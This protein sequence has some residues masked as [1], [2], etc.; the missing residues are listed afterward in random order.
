MDWAGISFGSSTFGVVA[1]RTGGVALWNGS[2]FQAQRTPPLPVVSAVWASATTAWVVGEGVLHFNGSAW[3]TLPFPGPWASVHG[4]AA[5]DVWLVGTG[6]RVARWNGSALT[7]FTS[8]ATTDLRAVHALSR[9]AVIVAG[10]GGTLLRFQGVGWATVTSGTSTNLLAL[11]RRGADV[12]A[13]GAQTALRV[14]T[15]GTVTALP[16]F[17]MTQPRAAIETSAGLWVFGSGNATATLHDGTSWLTLTPQVPLS[18]PTAVTLEG[19]RLWL[20]TTSGSLVVIDGAT[21]QVG[22][23]PATRPLVEGLELGADGTVWART[24]E[25]LMH[26]DAGWVVDAARTAAFR[27]L[28][29]R[30]FCSHHST[31]AKAVGTDGGLASQDAGS[32]TPPNITTP[33]NRVVCGARGELLAGVEST[34]GVAY[35][36]WFIKTPTGWSSPQTALGYDY[37]L[38]FF[39]GSDG[40]IIAGGETCSTDSVGRR[41]CVLATG[42]GPEPK[43]TMGSNFFQNAS[44]RYFVAEGASTRFILR[45]TPS[46]N[47]LQRDLKLG[48]VSGGLTTSAHDFT[49]A[50]SIQGMG[51]VDQ[52]AIVSDGTNVGVFSVDGGLEVEVLPRF[53]NTLVC[54][55]RTGQCFAGGLGLW[56]RDF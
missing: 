4:T 56:R 11:G 27:P 35:S 36:T 16:G 54:A 6:G 20:S 38:R 28:Q 14:T 7:P 15:Q 17:A 47:G 1:S 53:L 29:V 45:D 9:T 25:F 18:T 30:T 19:T 37:N 3:Q 32:M 46:S 13:L 23:A 50:S 5:D 34:L 44:S 8:G 41:V 42:S 55:P 48:I 51:V 52:R 39:T 12:V 26:T 40:G 31:D 21:W 33:L 10:N 24:T 43:R 2:Q 49:A 22:L